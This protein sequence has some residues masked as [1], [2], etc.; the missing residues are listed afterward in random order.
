MAPANHVAGG[1]KHCLAPADAD[2]ELPRLK[3]F[4]ETLALWMK[5]LKT[6]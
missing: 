2:T 1:Q 6:K 3:A 5:I 4:T